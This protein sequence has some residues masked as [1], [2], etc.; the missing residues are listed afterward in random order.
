MSEGLS[1]PPWEG[2]RR[3]DALRYVKAKGRA[4]GTPCC[5]CHQ[6]I[7]YSLS[8]PDPAS[9]SVQHTKSRKLFPHLTWESSL[10]QPA[11]LECNQ[12]A[13]VGGGEALGLMTE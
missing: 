8:Y 12:S 4:A 11:H 2:R 3:A 10:W 9:C 7:D 6:R 5:I 1:I 13:G